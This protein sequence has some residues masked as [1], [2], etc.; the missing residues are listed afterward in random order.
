MFTKCVPIT[1]YKHFKE[2]SVSDSFCILPE[3]LT[4]SGFLINI[5]SVMT[6]LTLGIKDSESS[7]AVPIKI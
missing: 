2:I 5:C 6:S 4:H 1:N 3:C 7:L